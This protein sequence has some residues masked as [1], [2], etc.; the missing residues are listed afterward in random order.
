M[1]GKMTT[2]MMMMMMMMP[3]SPLVLV[4]T[5]TSHYTEATIEDNQP[6]VITPQTE[7]NE[8]PANTLTALSQI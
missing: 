2:I 3:S 8:H 4:H 7:I 1:S 6:A 5:V